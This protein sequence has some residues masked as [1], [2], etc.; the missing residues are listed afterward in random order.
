MA[1]FSTE[2]QQSAYGVDPQVYRGSLLLLS[3]MGYNRSGQPNTWGKISSWLPGSSLAMARDA[4]SLALH[5]GATDT[6]NAI[7]QDADI[8]MQKFNTLI[9]VGQSVAGAVT[10]NAGLLQGGLQ[11]TLQSS[12]GLIAGANKPSPYPLPTVQYFGQGGATAGN[13]DRLPYKANDRTEDLVM[14][15]IMTG[16]PYGFMRYNE[17][18]FDQQSNSIMKRIM[19]SVKPEQ[20]KKKELGDHVYNELLTH[21][22]LRATAGSTDTQQGTNQP[23]NSLPFVFRMFAGG[24]E[25]NPDD[26]IKALLAQLDKMEQRQLSYEE[27]KRLKIDPTALRDYQTRL[28]QAKMILRSTGVGGSRSL[29]GETTRSRIAKAR[30]LIQEAGTIYPTIDKS[31][32]TLIPPTP[33]GVEKSAARLG[34]PT[35]ASLYPSVAQTVANYQAGNPSSVYPPAP[36]N[37]PV[38]TANAMAFLQSRPSLPAMLAGS[39]N[40]QPAGGARPLYPGPR[41]TP[42]R[43]APVPTPPTYGIPGLRVDNRR[44][45]EDGLF[46]PNSPV[47]PPMPTGPSDEIGM[48]YEYSTGKSTQVPIEPAGTPP[49]AEPS[50]AAVG[51]R[52][53]G[54]NGFDLGRVLTGAI[55]AGKPSKPYSLPFSYLNY[56]RQIEQRQNTGLSPN[57]LA[58]GQNAIANNYRAGVQNLTNFAGGSP[59]VALA[60]LARLQQQRSAEQV[61]LQAADNAAR[62]RNF[63]QYGNVVQQDL[64]ISQSEYMNQQARDAQRQQAG[65]NLSAA[66]IQNIENRRLHEM[67]Y[68]PNSLY[69][70][71]M[72]SYIR[73][74][75]EATETMKKQREAIMKKAVE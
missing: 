40:G 19:N 30:T 13:A 42:K 12:A 47:P 6:A 28:S 58:A 36:G 17:R 20:V 23:Y 32:N 69:Q 44:P 11:N 21:K 46:M 53:L 62:Q 71:L 10:G 5:N 16:K 68:G 75:D 66:G 55:I 63:A 74:S 43:T 72:T 15:D 37:T 65:L 8:R 18:I 39:V 67:Q 38:Q 14:I 70:K 41:P 24:G 22:D 59:G 57:E 73:Q 1:L 9:G 45:V 33:A 50:K 61:H 54:E 7:E 31:R 3:L 25:A 34:V 29:L 26:E 60:G 64:A 35:T 52:T 4:R 56:R 49:P 27:S 2:K 48:L 51:L